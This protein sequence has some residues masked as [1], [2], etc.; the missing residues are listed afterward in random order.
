MQVPGDRQLAP[1]LASSCSPGAPHSPYRS[2][3]AREETEEGVVKGVR[4]DAVMEAEEV[5][6]DDVRLRGRD[7][8]WSG[9][10]LGA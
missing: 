7:R 2:P 1:L 4:D 9:D 6:Q 10:W 8:P 3:D 5:E